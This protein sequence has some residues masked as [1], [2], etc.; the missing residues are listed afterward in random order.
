[1][2]I[3]KKYSSNELNVSQMFREVHAMKHFK[4]VAIV[5]ES[6]PLQIEAIDV[7]F[8]VSHLVRFGQFK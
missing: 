4:W 3:W 7:K 5:A 6:L 8:N 1:M 2:I